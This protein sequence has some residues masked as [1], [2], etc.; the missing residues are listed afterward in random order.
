MRI[1]SNI[2]SQY[3]VNIPAKIYYN[4]TMF[5][6]LI[7]S[8]AEAATGVFTHGSLSTVTHVPFHASM[9]G[10]ASQAGPMHESAGVGEVS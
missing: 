1:G 8:R 3:P 7:A 2:L 4:R 6:K 9:L 5:D 10:P